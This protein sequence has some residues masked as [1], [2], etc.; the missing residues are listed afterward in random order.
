MA[1]GFN[2]KQINL[3]ENI[4][5]LQLTTPGN[6]G[7]TIESGN[8]LLINFLFSK[9]PLIEIYETNLTVSSNSE[10]KKF[11]RSNTCDEKIPEGVSLYVR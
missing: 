1:L 2:K 5:I 8:S 7:I 10:L 4:F 3:N 9:K 6:I 11:T